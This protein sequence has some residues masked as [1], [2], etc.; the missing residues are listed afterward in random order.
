MNALE[1]KKVLEKMHDIFSDIV[2]DGRIDYKD[3]E[4]HTKVVEIFDESNNMIHQIDEAIRKAGKMPEGLRADIMAKLKAEAPGACLVV[5][6]AEW[7][8]ENL[9]EPHKEDHGQAQ[10]T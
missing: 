9:G 8:Y 7:D 1:V 4:E 6:E 10:Q 2:E 3:E 5:P